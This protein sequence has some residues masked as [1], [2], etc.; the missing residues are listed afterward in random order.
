MN[1]IIIFL[2][3]SLPITEAREILDAV[4]L[5]PA[6]QSDLI[7]AVT[8]YKP[9]II[10]LI[11]GVFLSYP[12]VWHKEILYALQQE[13]AVYGA[14]SMGA[15]RAAETSDFG[16]VGVGEIY[17]MYASGELIDDDEV[18]LIHGQEDTK[19]RPLSE[20]MVNVRATFRR[21][22]AEGM[23]SNNL[24]EQLTAIA[25]S[26]YFPERTF[27][28]IFRQA[29]AAGLLGD[30]LVAIE[31]FVKEKY[32]DI[33][34]QDAILLLETIKDLPKPLPKVTP[35]FDLKR[36]QFFATLYHR[37]RTVKRNN[38]NVPLGD[39]AGYATLHL[40]DFEQINLHACNRALVQIL[41]DFLGV[42]ATEVEVDKQSQH[43]RY[44]HNLTEE[45]AFADWLVQN[46][47]TLEEFKQLMSEI[48]RSH[49]LQKWLMTK[50]SY[51]QN[52]KILLDEL[53]LENRYQECA[54][55]AASR[56]KIIQKNYP[57]FSEE[58]NDDL[59][60]LQLAIE[61]QQSTGCRVSLRDDWLKEAGF[62]SPELLKLE[63]LRSH[64]A[65]KVIQNQENNSALEN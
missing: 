30:N 57:N 6:K 23:I 33:K 46:D 38:T 10:G 4:Y 58:N 54:D 28:V 17:R 48:A 60:I 12:S 53:R 20:P 14:S 18:A 56:E 61:H 1:K 44:Q 65:R 13:I 9:D 11:D 43:F 45:E 27:S 21:A 15:L 39:I 25:K 7:S 51:E 36:N 35:N 63:L 34:R 3:P 37:D 2:G 59:T 52:T 19:Y 49:Q 64:L 5:P 31:T 8:T 29:T 24:S 47:L 62:L 32:V 41:A 16:M 42:K 26:I 55:A 50:K 22:Q 40:P